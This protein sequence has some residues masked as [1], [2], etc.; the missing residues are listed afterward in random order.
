M[1]YVDRHSQLT[2]HVGSV[3]VFAMCLVIDWQ[4]RDMAGSEQAPAVVYFYPR[5]SCMIIMWDGWKDHISLFYLTNAACESYEVANNQ[6]Q[7]KLTMKGDQSFA[8]A[9]KDRRIEDKEFLLD[10]KEWTQVYNKFLY[11]VIIHFRGAM[12][13]TGRCTSATFS[14]T[15]T[16]IPSGQRS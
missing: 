16:E 10:L 5:R 6:L 1:H 13:N 12:P 2:I 3:S 11:A 8:T 15:T 7:V 9:T 4:S 14:T